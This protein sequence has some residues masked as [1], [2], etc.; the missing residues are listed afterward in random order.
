MVP[1]LRPIGRSSAL[2]RPIPTQPP[3]PGFIINEARVPIARNL[4]L[5]PVNTAVSV[6]LVAVTPN[7]NPRV[8]PRVVQL[9]LKL[10]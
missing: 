2:V 10:K 7:L 5:I 3:A 1:R 8:Q 6:G 4:H 9:D